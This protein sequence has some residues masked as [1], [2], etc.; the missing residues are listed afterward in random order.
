MIWY[1]KGL[2][3]VPQAVP[4]SM[5]QQ[6][7]PAMGFGTADFSH[8]EVFVLRL[9]RAT[10]PLVTA[11]LIPGRESRPQR[12]HRA[13]QELLALQEEYQEWLENLP[14]YLE[15]TALAEKLQAVCELD[16]EELVDMEL[17]LGFGRD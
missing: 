9:G 14:E 12:W 10:L 1:F 4:Q 17:P 2:K 11:S 5:C 3:T 8:P 13:V 16:L 15:G 7:S 6:I